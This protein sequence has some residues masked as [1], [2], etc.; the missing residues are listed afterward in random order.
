MGKKKWQLYFLWFWILQH[1]RRSLT[2]SSSIL[3]LS[4]IFFRLVPKQSCGFGGEGWNYFLRASFSLRQYVWIPRCGLQTK[5]IHRWSKT[6]DKAVVFIESD[7]RT[8]S[9]E[10]NQKSVTW[11]WPRHP[12]I[13]TSIRE[14]DGALS[15]KVG[16]FINYVQRWTLRRAV[17]I[18]L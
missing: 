14:I 11:R 12:E 16:I 6:E 7:Q 3:I 17:L 4:Q 9:E 18:F 13:Y 1:V 8:V 2:R 15:Y 5:I 10:R